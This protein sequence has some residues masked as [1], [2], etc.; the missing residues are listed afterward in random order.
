MTVITGY[1]GLTKKRSRTPNS[2]RGLEE[3]G[4]A[5]TRATRLTQQLIAFGRKQILQPQIIDLNLIVSNMEKMLK[6]LIGETIELVTIPS[7]GLGK[8]KADPGQI[9]QVVVNLAL[10]ARDAMPN[11]GRITI[12]TERRPGRTPRANAEIRGPYVE[13]VFRDEGAG[14]DEETKTHIFEPYFTTK[15]VGKGWDWDWRRCT[16]SS[17]RAEAISRSRVSRE[18]ARIHDLASPG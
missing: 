2:W 18:K 10:N 3:I 15:E 17:A 1:V 12:E 16:A 14:M 9:E 13:L 4:K 11:G 5:S 8:V 7:L 6:H